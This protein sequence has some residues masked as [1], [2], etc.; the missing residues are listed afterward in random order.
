MRTTVFGALAMS[1]L[2]A[3]CGSNTTQRA[4]TG[5]L[6]GIGAGALI[7]GPI[8]AV[9]GG[10]IG[11]VAGS[12]MPEGADTMAKQAANKARGAG[13]TALNDVGMG[14]SPTAASGTSQP[15]SAQ[16]AQAGVSPGSAQTTREAQ[17]ELKREGLYHGKI[18]GIDGPQTQQATTAFQNREGLRQTASLDR[19]TLDRLHMAESSSAQANAAPNNRAMSGTSTASA[20]SPSQLREKLS[21]AGYSNISDLRHGS[22]NDWTAQ[23]DR[24]GQSLSLRVDG[25]TGRVID[26]QALNGSQP[27][28]TSSGSSTNP[29]AGNPAAGANPAPNPSAD[30]NSN[31]DVNTNGNAGN[32]PG[33][34]H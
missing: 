25:T 27:P 31:S 19:E 12:V 21:Q 28:A 34:N 16:A 32:P 20:L 7:G 15:S 4:A 26:Q 13:Q 5:G 14:S 30:I 1:L 23:A 2:L 8:G 9:A 17:R 24:N 18:D 33:P 29:S 6:T 10:A 3:A 22:G 11:A